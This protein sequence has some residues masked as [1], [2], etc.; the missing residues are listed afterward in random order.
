MGVSRHR[1]RGEL[2][3]NRHRGKHHWG[4]P[5]VLLLL[6][7]LLGRPLTLSMGGGLR[8]GVIQVTRSAIIVVKPTPNAPI[9][10]RP[11]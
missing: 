11:S 9:R 3:E 10:A 6:L 7:L 4:G 5:L 1:G 8:V 2:R